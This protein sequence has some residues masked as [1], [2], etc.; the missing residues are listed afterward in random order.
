[1][2]VWAKWA[3]TP[4]PPGHYHSPLPDLR[5]APLPGEVE[6]PPSSLPGIDV[7]TEEQLALAEEFVGFYRDMPFE[8]EPTDGLRYHLNCTW[9]AHGDGVALHSML[10]KIRPRRY[11]EV[12]SGWSSACALDTAE[13]FLDGAVEFSFIEPNPERLRSVLR[14]SDNARIIEDAGTQL[15]WRLFADLEP[16]D[17]LFVDSSHVT[18]YGSEVNRLVL[19]VFPRLPAGVH[20]HVH[21]IFWPFSYPVRWLRKGRAWNEAYLLR[22][23]L[24]DNP[25]AQIRWFNNYLAM[26]AREDLGPRMPAWNIDP[27]TSIWIETQ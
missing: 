3:T 22:A 13:L 9:F 11:V 15:D 24:C 20:I 5:P 27:G 18:K 12:G 19:D 23:W 26:V 8:E 4:Y 17:V 14:P 21:D 25:R 16:G 1:L 2:P 6:D 10:R 7:H